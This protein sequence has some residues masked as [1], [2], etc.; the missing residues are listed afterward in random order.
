MP[1]KIIVAKDEKGGIGVNNRLPW[2]VKEDMKRFVSLT[3]GTGKNAVLMGR[4]TWDSLPTRPLVCRH[5]LILSRSSFA[6]SSTNIVEYDEG[7]VTLFKDIEY[8]LEYIKEKKFEDVW[9]IG[10]EKLYS[11]FMSEPDLNKLVKEVYV[12]EIAGDYGCDVFF[13]E[14]DVSHYEEFSS[15]CVG[16]KVKFKVYHNKLWVDC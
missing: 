2:R 8:V 14:L 10:G 6:Y 12:T 4:N 1:F 7:S 5:N 3:R 16:E 9:I 15:E 11:E 13:K